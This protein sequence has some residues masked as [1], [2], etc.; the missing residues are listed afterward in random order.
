MARLPRLTQLLGAV[1]ACAQLGPT[2]AVARPITSSEANVP[3]VDLHVDVPY[4][5]LFKHAEL[6]TGTGQFNAAAASRAGVAAVVLPLFV[7]AQVRPGG[8]RMQDYESSWQRLE[9]SLH[10][11]AVY[12]AP[13][14]EA[15]AG[16]VRTFYSFEG[17]APFTDDRDTLLRWVQRG[18]RLFGLVH[19][20]SNPLA[21]AALDRRVPDFGL[22][23]LGRRVAVQIYELGG[24]VDVSHASERATSDVLEI[25][26][27]LGKPVVASHSNAKHLLDHPRNLSDLAIDRI[28]R[29]GGLIGVNFHSPFLTIE[30]RAAVTDVVNQVRYLVSRAG[31]EH[32]AIG[33]DFEGDIRTPIG[34]SSVAQ[35]QH[36]ADALRRS[37]L[38]E[39]E[40]EAVMGGNALSLLA[41]RAAAR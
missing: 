17:M 30:R 39:R 23:E 24:I 37:G 18:V 35:I 12:A 25:A 9:A 26:E 34:L 32:V 11:Q 19:N 4:Q 14:R 7:P 6:V 13:N 40:V 33:S 8:P 3:Y 31:A 38:T 29:T 27:R 28:A 5:H 21:A 16:Q 10:R 41:P 15:S 2:G 20:Q 1:W 36:L 22:S